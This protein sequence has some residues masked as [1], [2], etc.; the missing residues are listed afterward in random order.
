MVGE[1][2]EATGPLLK[3]LNVL[4]SVP[5]VMR[6]SL[7]GDHLRAWTSLEVSQEDLANPIMFHGMNS[8]MVEPSE[9]NM[10]DV[11]MSLIN[12]GGEILR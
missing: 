2:Q 10:E 8:V 6:A 9:P 3:C 7:A 4:E 11:F 12:N 1:E 5:G